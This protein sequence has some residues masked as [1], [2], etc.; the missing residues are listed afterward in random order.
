MTV[1]TQSMPDK[2]VAGSWLARDYVRWSPR[3]GG[4]PRNWDLDIWKFG[5]SVCLWRYPRVF[6]SW[7]RDWRVG[8]DPHCIQWSR[9]GRYTGY[10]AGHHGV[11][12]YLIGISLGGRWKIEFGPRG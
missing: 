6:L 10:G 2:P 8:D 3:S 7:A 11:N 12:W 5:I 9:C 4:F 1:R